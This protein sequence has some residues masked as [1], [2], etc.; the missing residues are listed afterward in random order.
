MILNSTWIQLK[1][2]KMWQLQ[3]RSIEIENVCILF[4]FSRHPILVHLIFC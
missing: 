1:Y 3:M 4:R 2:A